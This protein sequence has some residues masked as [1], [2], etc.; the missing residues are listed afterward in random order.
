MLHCLRR[1]VPSLRGSN[2]HSALDK[3]TK[4]ACEDTPAEGHCAGKTQANVLYAT[5][6]PSFP[7]AGEITVENS[8]VQLRRPLS[9]KLTPP[10]GSEH[11]SGDVGPDRSWANLL[12]VDGDGLELAIFAAHREQ[13]CQ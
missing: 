12:P 10:H 8:V 13:I 2:W 1:H 6:P 11:E 9:I 7:E 5:L 3:L 4:E